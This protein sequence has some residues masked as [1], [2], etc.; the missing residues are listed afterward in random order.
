M[1]SYL[2]V[3]QSLSIYDKPI[4]R[5]EA[6]TQ[7]TFAALSGRKPAEFKGVVENLGKIELERI[8]VQARFVRGKTDNSSETEL[9]S[10]LKHLGSVAPAQVQ[11]YTPDKPDAKSGLKPVTK[12]T[13]ESI[14]NK[15]ADKTGIPVE[16]VPA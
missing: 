15:V 10:W 12:S 4:L 8:I 16:I 2:S 6:G 1:L 11:L 5:L 9:R 7:K 3:R 13:L 14:A